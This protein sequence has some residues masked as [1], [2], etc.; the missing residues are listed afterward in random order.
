MALERWQTA[1]QAYLDAGG[2]PLN[3]DRRKGSVTKILPWKV[4]QKVLWDFDE[5]K[6]ADE[7]ISWIKKKIRLETSMAPRSAAREA[8][9]LEELD[10]EGQQELQALGDDA[11]ELEVNAVFRRFVGRGGARGGAGQRGPWKPK[12]QNAETRAPSRTPAE[13]SCPNCL[14]KGHTGAECTKPKIELGARKCFLCKQTGHSA[15]HCPTK[16]KAVHNVEVA[17]GERVPLA[18]MDDD[19]FIP[20]Q[21]RSI[22]SLPIPCCIGHKAI[23]ERRLLERRRPMPMQRRLEDFIVHKNVFASLAMKVEGG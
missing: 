9:A 16:P 7:L 14:E 18:M 4:Q 6:S 2:E 23:P 3:D 17:K 1:V 5:Y 21:R 15:R 12:A 11:S 19:G 10:E 13:S 22:T 8:H 20:I